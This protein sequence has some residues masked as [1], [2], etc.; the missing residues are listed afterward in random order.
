MKILSKLLSR[1]TT[2]THQ[3]GSTSED[4]ILGWVEDGEIRPH[5]R[6]KSS[7]N[8]RREVIVWPHPSKR[9]NGV[10]NKMPISAHG[11]KLRVIRDSDNECVGCGMLGEFWGVTWGKAH[12]NNIVDLYGQKNGHWY[13]MTI[14][15]VIPKSIGGTSRL[16]NLV[17]MC[18]NCNHGKAN[19]VKLWQRIHQ[20]FSKLFYKPNIPKNANPDRQK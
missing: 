5:I 7:S 17:V 4:L 1:P 3:I 2:T 11:L 9:R 16:S 18:A 13:P 20:F 12:N 19:E 8:T 15:H 10:N 14:D 6:R